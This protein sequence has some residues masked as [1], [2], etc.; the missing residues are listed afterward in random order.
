MKTLE[1]VLAEHPFFQ[2]LQPGDLQ[3]IA[4]CASNV[5]FEAGEYLFRAGDPADSFHL[6]RHGRVALEVS[7]PGRGP[8]TILTVGEGEVLGWSFLVPPYRKQFDARALEL[9]RATA[10]DGVCIRR[11][12]DE[13]PR[14]GYDLLKRF[15]QVIGQRL[16][17][18]RLQ[19]LDVYGPRR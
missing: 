11:K 9:T 13:D 8:I 10:F 15:A 18:A 17:A 4:G 1:A 3:L 2:G 7:S 12:C 19:L 16:Q 5:R 6:I 14:L